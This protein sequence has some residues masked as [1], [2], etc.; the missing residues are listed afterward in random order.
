M[1]ARRT[2]RPS[3][4]ILLIAGNTVSSLGNAVYL[5]AVTL[6]LYDITGSAALLGLFQFLALAPGFLLSPVTGALI[7]R[8]SRRSVII[9]ADLGRGVL[10]LVAGLALLIPAL[11]TPWLILPVSLL[12][13]VGHAF[14]VPAAQA[15]VPSLVEPARLQ[16]AN[17]SRAAATQLANL[18]GNAIGGAL[19][20]LLGAP[21][22]FV[23]NGVSF[24]LSAWQE[25]LIP[26]DSVP[27]AQT[28]ADR[29]GLFAAAREGLTLL[30]GDA[31]LRL[32]IGS[33]AGLF[34]ISPVLLLSVPF[35]VIDQLGLAEAVV[36]LVFA[37]ALAGGIAVFVGLRKLPPA[38]LTA[39]PLPEAG[40]LAM[41][42]AFALLARSAAAPI[43]FAV[44]LTS[45][46][47]AALVY[48]YGV[49]WIQ[50]RSP[51]RFHGRLFAIFEAASAAVAPLSYVLAGVMLDAAGS[52]RRWMLFAG[53]A[54]I[55]LGWLGV[56][57]LRRRSVG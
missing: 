26:R 55:S 54:A 34:V 43:L 17:G 13:G 41:A 46:A 49:T 24:L 19:Y 38:T 10:M 57:V 6:L 5:I 56:L 8:L 30:R 36:G 45:G 15:L 29:G 22:L 50:H 2:P 33:Q 21:L 14:F 1:A 16:A 12:A 23:G 4:L 3:G 20:A 47:A 7:D 9:L 53:V 40:Y 42:L 28:D 27:A 31:S 18:S 32:V 37:A 48:L 52:E 11:R 35:V 39:L 25:S 44:S 51:A